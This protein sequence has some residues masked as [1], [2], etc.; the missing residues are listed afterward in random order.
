MFLPGIFNEY[1]LEESVNE[2]PVIKNEL[3][4]AKSTTKY[5]IREFSTIS[6]TGPPPLRTQKSVV[7]PTASVNLIPKTSFW[8]KYII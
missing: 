7:L 4:K 2:E 6:F 3:M 8:G 1:I 5:L